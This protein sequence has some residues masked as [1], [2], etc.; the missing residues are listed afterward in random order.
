MGACAFINLPGSAKIG[1]GE[2][3]IDEQQDNVRG[4]AARL[5]APM[6][7]AV[8][9]H[10]QHSADRPEKSDARGQPATDFHCAASQD[11]CKSQRDRAE[12]Q[13]GNGDK[14]HVHM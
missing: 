10:L 7:A 6:T 9:S 8:V 5:S 11:W 13:Q 4:G 14:P 2:A 1:G 3:A 12:D